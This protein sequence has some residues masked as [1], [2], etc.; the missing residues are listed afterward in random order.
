MSLHSHL[1]LPITFLRVPEIHDGFPWT[2]FVARNTTVEDVLDAVSDELGLTRVLEGPGGGN[3]DYIME[4]VV[5]NGSSA[6]L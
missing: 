6:G 3:V 2:V 5:G 1:T 4:E